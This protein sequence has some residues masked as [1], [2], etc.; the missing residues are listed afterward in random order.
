[1]TMNPYS[2]VHETRGGVRVAIVSMKADHLVNTVNLFLN[3]IPDQQIRNYR[4][5]AYHNYAPENMD[6]KVRRTMGLR[7]MSDKAKQDIEDTLVELEERI[8]REM[9]DKAMPY[10]I[11]GITRDDTRDGVV[12][13]LQNLTGITGQIDYQVPQA[14][15]DNDDMELLGDYHNDLDDEPF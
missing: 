3:K 11:V 4:N 7:K 2:F 9:I 13:I 1:M 6:E 14:R 12:A 8:V 10:I 15:I 5:E